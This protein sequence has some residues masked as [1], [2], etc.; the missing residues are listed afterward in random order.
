MPQILCCLCQF[1]HV[2]SDKCVLWFFTDLKLFFHMHTQL[3]RFS[4]AESLVENKD[5]PFEINTEADSNDIDKHMH[6]ENLQ[7]KLKRHQNRLTF[8]APL[9]RLSIV[10]CCKTSQ[11]L[12]AQT[13]QLQIWKCWLVRCT[14]CVHGPA[15]A[16]AILSSLI[17]LTLILGHCLIPDCPCFFCGKGPIYECF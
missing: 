17:S 12:W 15:D 11:P 14:W 8:S 9:I 16:T 2:C 5:Q 7:N 6:T 4:D 1:L 13:I 10:C 3:S